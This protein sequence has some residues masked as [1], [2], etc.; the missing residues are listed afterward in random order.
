MK[1]LIAGFGNV[2]RR[3]DAFGPLLVRALER[4]EL[5][6]GVTLLEAG[7]GGVS[8]VQ[9]LQGGYDAAILLDA[10]EG[11]R[12]GQ[13]KTMSLEVRDPASLGTRAARDYLADI[14]YAEPGRALALAKGIGAL[15]A[16]TYLVGCV[17][18]S[19]DLGEGLSAPVANALS[20]A[21]ER[22]IELLGRLRRDVATSE[23]TRAWSH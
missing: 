12:P 1:V 18:R 10:V 19:C 23:G 2:L 16:R 6:A 5:G 7:I 13:V 21:E 8:R 17:P 4:R 22:V 9:E 20:E 15:P 14:H 11:D 3:D